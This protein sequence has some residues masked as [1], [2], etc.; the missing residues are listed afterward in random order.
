MEDRLVSLNKK[1]RFIFE[2]KSL[3]ENIKKAVEKVYQEYR[4]FFE[5][6]IKPDMLINGQDVAAMNF[7][8]YFEGEYEETLRNINSKYKDRCIEK[9]EVTN[10]VLFT[11][12][13][14]KSENLDKQ[15][16]KEETSMIESCIKNDKSNYSYSDYIVNKVIESI[17]SSKNQ[18]F[19]VLEGLKTNNQKM[20]YI[21]ERIKLIENTA[22]LSLGRLKEELDIDDEQ[23]LRQIFDE[24]EQYKQNKEEKNENKS[25]HQKFVEQYAVPV[26]D[27]QKKSNLEKDNASQEKEYKSLPG[28]VIK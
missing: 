4:E 25:E 24:Y 27:L 26:E 10:T 8:R 6:N 3:P 1:I 17:E 20:Q 19:R 22:K 28:D 5:E 12:E 11:I 13:S 21:Y 14:Q 23:I 7:E 9:A 2:E 15:M 18:M 16:E